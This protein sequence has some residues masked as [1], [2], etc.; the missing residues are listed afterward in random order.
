[1]ETCGT[2][3][4]CQGLGCGPEGGG[5]LLKRLSRELQRSLLQERAHWLLRGGRWERGRLTAEGPTT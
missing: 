4:L 2:R 3:G 5:E 1:M